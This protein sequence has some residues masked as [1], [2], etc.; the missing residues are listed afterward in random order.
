[1]TALTAVTLA[2]IAGCMVVPR[3]VSSYNADCQVVERH[4]TLEAQQI[5]ALARCHNNA[6]CATLLAVYGLVAATSAVVSGSV[7]VVGNVAYWIEK[8]GQ[9][10]RP[11]ASQGAPSIDLASKG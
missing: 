4:M 2:S 6:E 1:M 3:T 10:T 7:A 8:Q 5:G 11:P 9:C